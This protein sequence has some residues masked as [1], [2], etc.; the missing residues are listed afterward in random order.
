LIEELVGFLRHEAASRRIPIRTDLMQ[1]MPLIKAD[2]VQLQQVV[3]NLVMNGMDAMSEVTS[4][5]K[6]ILI[7]SRKNGT[8]EALVAVQDYGRGI[9]SQI[10]E[11]IFDPF[12][13]TKSQGLGMGLSISRSIIESH[14]GRLWATA[15]P[16]GGATFQF[17]IPIR[18]QD[19][20][21]E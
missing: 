4:T 11:K 5:S 15:N 16:M 1:S 19:P 3:L 8:N 9:D 20:C 2:R 21:D 14:E 10:L 12:F 17:T 18:A 6:E 7:S 13:T